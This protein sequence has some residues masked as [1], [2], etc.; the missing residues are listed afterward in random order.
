MFCCEA[1]SEMIDNA[2]KRGLGIVPFKG[3]GLSYF[4]LQ[5]RACDQEELASLQPGRSGVSLR[6]AEQMGIRYCPSCGVNLEKWIHK[7]QNH[8]DELWNEL[9]DYNLNQKKFPQND[10]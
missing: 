7:N 2:G 10:S 8:F 6:L 3:L 9:K 5:S 1:F 4:C